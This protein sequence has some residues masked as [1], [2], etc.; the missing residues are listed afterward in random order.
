MC[1]LLLTADRRCA[2]SGGTMGLMHSP[3]ALA[4]AGRPTTTLG[5]LTKMYIPPLPFLHITPLHFLPPPVPCPDLSMPDL[6]MIA[7]PN[8]KRCLMPAPAIPA[9]S[10]TDILFKRLLLNAVSN[11]TEI[12]GEEA[13]EQRNSPCI[14][15]LHKH[16]AGSGPP[17]IQP[18]S[19]L[20]RRPHT[21]R[22]LNKPQHE[23][24]ERRGA[25][26][27][28]FRSSERCP[29]HFFLG[30]RQAGSS[31]ELAGQHCALLRTELFRKLVLAGAPPA[32]VGARWAG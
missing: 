24:H 27:R 25:E 23:H 17:L 9:F 26:V 13:Q 12:H 19:G 22:H 31:S 32:T 29:A 28:Q 10:L 1:L 21:A 20:V 7:P 3:C 16:S 14:V 30:G 5:S 6:S 11:A 8:S 18:R 4:T 15:C 2:V